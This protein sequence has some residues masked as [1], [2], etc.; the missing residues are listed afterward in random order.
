MIQRRE[1][2]SG[3]V[4]SAYLSR[5]QRLD[6]SLHAIV[7]LDADGAHRQA[8]AADTALS[9]GEVWG[10]LHGVPITLEDYHPTAG[11]R[12][13]W[14]GMPAFA[15]HVPAEDGVIPARL[16]SAGA[17]L[18]GKTYGPWVWPDSIFPD[19]IN[20]WSPV[21]TTGGSSTGPAVALAA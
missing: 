16:K 9:R 3:E 15:D 8:R 18:L 10:P 21:H 19:P 12:S 13:T 20:P 11:L 6:P 1:V 14:G 2:S 7:T 4:T 17:V 5:I